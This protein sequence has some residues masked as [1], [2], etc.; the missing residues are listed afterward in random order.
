MHFDRLNKILFQSINIFILYIV[1]PANYINRP[2][3]GILYSA[4]GFVIANGKMNEIIAA[5]TYL[6]AISFNRVLNRNRMLFVLIGFN[7]PAAVFYREVFC[8]KVDLK[9]FAFF[10]NGFPKA[11]V[12]IGATAAA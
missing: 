12:G 6:Y 2:A 9:F 10:V 11:A 3:A 4:L 8:I 5:V 1:A 7:L